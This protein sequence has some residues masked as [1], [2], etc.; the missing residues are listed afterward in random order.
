MNIGVIFTVPNLSFID[1]QARKLFHL[2][3]DTTNI[4]FKEQ[5]AHLKIYKFQHNSLYDKT[6]TPHPT[7][8]NEDGAR[9][10]YTHIVVPKPRADLV[11]AYEER[12]KEYTFQLNKNVLNELE[13][14]QN[15]DKQDKN[16]NRVKCIKCDSSTIRYRAKTNTYLCRMCG[17]VW[18]MGGTKQ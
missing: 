18:E 12:K 11:E 17:M 4:D 16:V 8:Y 10:T 14:S 5:K 9:I 7:H 6:Y 3:L 2:Y 1:V 15:H 13:A